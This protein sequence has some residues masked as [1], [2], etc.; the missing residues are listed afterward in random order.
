MADVSLERLML[1]PLGFV[2]PVDCRSG[3]SA[4]CAITRL[5]A[6]LSVGCWERDVARGF[7]GPSGPGCELSGSH[8]QILGRS[9]PTESPHSSL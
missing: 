8:L 2:S 1:T 3:K 4:V 9:N 6:D 5:S 7:R